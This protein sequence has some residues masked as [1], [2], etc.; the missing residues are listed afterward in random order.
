LIQDLG[1]E[2]GDAQSLHIVLLALDISPETT[3]IDLTR[4][5]F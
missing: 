5:T 3:R 1:L 4:I 2:H